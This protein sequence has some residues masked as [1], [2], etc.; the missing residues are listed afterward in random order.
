MEMEYNPKSKMPN[1][2]LK[3]F[4]VFCVLNLC[5]QICQKVL[6]RRTTFCLEIFDV[7]DAG[8]QSENTELK[9]VL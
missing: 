2:V 8:F 9:T 1:E 3:F 4:T 6:K 5:Q 7:F